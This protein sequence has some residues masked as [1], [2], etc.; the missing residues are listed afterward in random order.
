MATNLTDLVRE[1]K[2]LQKDL[3]KKTDDIF[4]VALAEQKDAPWEIKEVAAVLRERVE[5]VEAFVL[6][7]A[8]IILENETPLA[9]E[10]KDEE[11]KDEEDEAEGLTPSPRSRKARAKRKR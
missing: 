11:E 1:T 9:E 3:R 4:T 5:A 8:V 6:Q 2:K 10:E 7:L